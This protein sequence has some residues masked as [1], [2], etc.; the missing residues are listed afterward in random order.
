MIAPF[1]PGIDDKRQAAVR[2]A[3]SRLCPQIYPQTAPNR[4]MAATPRGSFAT[5]ATILALRAPLHASAP[6][7]A[8]AAHLPPP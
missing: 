1:A 2:M 4:R 8:S 5:T 7:W 6:R 3:R